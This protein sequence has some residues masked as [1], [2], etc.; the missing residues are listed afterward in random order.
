MGFLPLFPQDL[1]DERDRWDSVLRS[2]LPLLGCLT[3]GRASV[4]KDSL[5]H[6]LEQCGCSTDQARKVFTVGLGTDQQQNCPQ[7]LSWRVPR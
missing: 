6:I 2:P 4:G 3:Q 1:K 7:G 5:A